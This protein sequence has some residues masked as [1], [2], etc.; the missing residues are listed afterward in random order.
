MT[1]YQKFRKLKI[2]HS[3][4]ELGLC[5][6]EEKYFCTPKGARIIGS[7][8]VDGIHYCFVRGQEE[9]VFAVSPMNTP[10]R[11]VFPIARTFEEL[12]RLLLACGSMAAL[13]QVHQWDEEQFEEYIV[14]N[15]PTAEAVAV[16]EVLKDKLG[17][18]PME[19]PFAYL[20]RLQD[21]YNYRGL[22]FSKE[23][24]DYLNAYPADETPSE[25]KV[26]LDGGFH[27]KR[28][29][30]GKEIT[31]N[32]QFV[33]GD[34]LWHV[35]A[36]YLFGG[37]L[38][39]DFCVQLNTERVRAFYDK[40][41]QLKEQGIQLSEEELRIRNESPTE[42]N[43]HPKLSVNGETLRNSSGQGQIWIAS[44]ILGDDFW[45]DR[46][47]R[48]ILE[49]YGLDLS[50]AWVVRRCSFTWEGRRAIEVESLNLCLERD[51]TDIPGIRFQ[52]PV[53]GES[54]KFIHPV[55]DVEHR[56]T[57]H[58]LEMQEMK[59]SRFHDNELEFPR[60]FAVLT[61][62]I[63]PELAR[64]AFILKDCNEGDCPR[65]KNPDER[66]RYAMSVGAVAIIRSSD[67]PTQN[68]CVDGKEVKPYV[69][70]SSLH[71]EPVCEPIEWQLIFREKMMADMEVELV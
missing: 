33:W 42:I 19:E 14:E 67:G 5:H 48:W 63:V 71:F 66:G 12:L 30:S 22:N 47:G 40:Y 23:Y 10:G 61:Y 59:E 21:S 57:V 50:K 27:P 17:I 53:V 18:T 3:A 4:I 64:D 28:G 24:Y 45:E 31:L 7:A 46:Y 55:T 8:G 52:T 11:N 1:L 29:K 49:H 60:N 9:M 36:V 69:I 37:G 39:V 70:C 6:A 34:E 68:Y 44:E 65:P 32:K 62:T 51:K 43:F 16:F 35:P 41:K 54:V 26:T 38:V 25:W 20:C 56:L 58:E 15:Q 13:E 2:N